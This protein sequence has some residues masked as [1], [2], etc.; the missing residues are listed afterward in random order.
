MNL[1]LHPQ[2]MYYIHNSFTQYVI[3]LNIAEKDHNKTE[4]GLAKTP[5]ETTRLLNPVY[6]EKI[7]WNEF[8]LCENIKML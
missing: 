7:F 3:L 1:I 8:F 2:P 6:I 5:L 4:V